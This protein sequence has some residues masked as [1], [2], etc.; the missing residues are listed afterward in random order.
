MG[1]F[2]KL[3]VL[4]IGVIIVMILVVAIYTWT[5]NPSGEETAA[6]PSETNTAMGT[7]PLR[8]DDPGGSVWRDFVDPLPEGDDSDRVKLVHEDDLD[9]DTPSEDAPEH[10]IDPEPEP[11]DDVQ[12]QEKTVTVKS[13]ETLSHI[14]L[15]AYGTVKY[16]PRIA[17]RN[18]V[19]PESIRPGMTLIIP[20]IERSP[21][22]G[23]KPSEVAVTGADPKAGTNYTV[24]GGDTIQKIS[25]AAFG[26]IE[27]WTDIWFENFERIEDP[28]F[29]RSGMKIQIPN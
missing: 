28:R 29:L 16:W 18:N 2:E 5:D 22:P 24:R 19:K 7:L 1:N 26:T 25:Q 9:K 12:A 27:R 15:R 6:V 10:G 13:G 4:V 21:V 23:N 8:T 3:S 17:E 20:V 14:S 11:S